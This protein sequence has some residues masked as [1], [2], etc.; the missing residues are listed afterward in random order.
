MED[1][2][3]N[4]LMVEKKGRKGQSV[5][6]LE[7]PLTRLQHFSL[8]LITSASRACR[9]AAFFGVISAESV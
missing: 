9:L 7:A 2:K 1:R 4:H 6:L 8:C 5:F 3:M